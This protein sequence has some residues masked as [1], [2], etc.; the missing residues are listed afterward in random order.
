[1]RQPKPFFRKQTKS[2]YVQI[3]KRQINLGRDKE[4]AW[5]KYHEMMLDQSEPDE[6]DY[7]VDLL[8]LYLEWLQKNRSE[9]TYLKALGYLKQFAGYVGRT[10]RT[11]QLTPRRVSQWIEEKVT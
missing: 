3:R 5:K 11:D 2:W 9:G 10:L 1:M 6:V 8:D 4:A 7:V